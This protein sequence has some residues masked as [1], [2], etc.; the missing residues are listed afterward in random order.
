M[1]VNAA[2]F[3]VQILTSHFENAQPVLPLY[4]VWLQLPLLPFTITRVG[5]PGLL[6][7]I[8]ARTAA[9]V[10]GATLS[11]RFDPFVFTL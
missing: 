9:F 1:K 11:R 5:L 2:R 10:L 3:L 4:V 6:F 7:G 8:D